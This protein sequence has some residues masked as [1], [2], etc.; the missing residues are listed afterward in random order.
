MTTRRPSRPTPRRS[1]A[2]APDPAP[3]AAPALAPGRRLLLGAGALLPLGAVLAACGSSVTGPAASPAAGGAV[4]ISNCGSQVE[5]AGPPRAA[6]GLHPSQTELLLRLGQRESIVGQAQAEAQP[7]PEDVADLAADI[8]VI[9]GQTPP[10]REE[11]L[12]AEPDFVYA[13]TTYE[14]SGEQGFA[15]VEQLAQAGAAVYVATGGCADRRMTGTVEDL[16]TDLDNLGE[17]FGIAERAGELSAQQRGTLEE[18]SAAV[19]GREPVRTAQVYVEGTTLSVIGAGVEHDILL[20]AGA[21]PVHGPD[22]DLFA[23]FFAA[24][25]SPEALAAEEPAA[26]V[27]GVHDAAHEQAT[28]DYLTST[29]PQMPAVAESRLIAVPSTSL[30]PGTLGN[31]SAVRTIAEALHPGA[32]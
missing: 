5:L 20:R 7:L 14:F 19:S 27:F 26:L 13:P 17:I 18:V 1:A 12:A 16:F 4:S 11:L 8:P 24:Q 28:R 21:D 22:Q 10:A 2:P 32:L 30:F 23:D 29:F 31:V 6:I 3:D 15:T 9:G 25:I